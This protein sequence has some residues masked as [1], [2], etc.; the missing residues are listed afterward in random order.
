MASKFN[1]DKVIGNISR[2]KRSIPIVV[3]NETKRYFLSSWD[4]QGWDGERWKDPQRLSK[5]G[6]STRL[7]SAI[8][9]QSGTLR[10]AVNNSLVSQTFEKIEFAVKDVPYAAI[11]NDGLPMK[12]GKPMPKRRYMGQTK[13]LTK[14]QLTTVKKEFDKVWRG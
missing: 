2:L 10:R 1:F 13:E 3:G 6:T 11:H 12:N 7:R 14:I 4:K 9:V 5:K 8:L